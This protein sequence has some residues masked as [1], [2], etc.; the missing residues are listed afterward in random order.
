MATRE[1]GVGESL[2]KGEGDVKVVIKTR[3]RRD[4]DNC[5]EPAT[6]RIT[7]CYVN[8]RRNPASSMYGRDDC[9]Y[10]ADAEAFA[11]DECERNVERV[12]CPDGMKWGS[13]FTAS[14]HSAHMFLKWGEKEV[15]SQE[16]AALL[17]ARG[18][19]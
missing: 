14:D 2:L 19:A 17:A 9:S 11:C 18:N 4:C 16:A 5:G 8:G 15:D 1:G 12:C 6:K 13:I 3:Y 7:Y 10:C